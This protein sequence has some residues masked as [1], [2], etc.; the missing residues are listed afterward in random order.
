MAG[1]SELKERVENLVADDEIEKAL[2]LIKGEISPGNRCRN[3]L[4]HL[5]SRYNR[6]K[7]QRSKGLVSAMDERTEINQITYATLEFKDKL[8]EEDILEKA[9]QPIRPTTQSLH[10]VNTAHVSVDNL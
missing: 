10:G 7:N 6:I 3:E 9:E 2:Q 1:L 5:L 4:L 8:R